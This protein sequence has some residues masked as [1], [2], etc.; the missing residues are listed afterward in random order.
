MGQLGDGTTVDRLS[1]VPVSG[2][3][4]A[5]GV[6]A[7]LGH[8]VAVAASATTSAWGW[9]HYG[10]VG[11]GTT[12]MATTPVAVIGLGRATTVAAGV[13]HTIAAGVRA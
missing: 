5:A 1:P 2:L 8:S 13:T 10:Q 4:G 11:N 12:T 7:G 6:A 9:N 3:S